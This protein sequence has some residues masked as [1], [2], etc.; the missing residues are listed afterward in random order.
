MG[1]AMGEYEGTDSISEI[2]T[3]LIEYLEKFYSTLDT[4]DMEAITS[5]SEGVANFIQLRE[6]GLRTIIGAILEED[7]YFKRGPDRDT[8]IHLPDSAIMKATT[9]IE[10]VACPDR[11]EYVIR[12]KIR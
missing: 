9:A 11:N 5:M 6:Q 10:I 7:I 4:K 2:E 3:K 1:E 8:S 12:R